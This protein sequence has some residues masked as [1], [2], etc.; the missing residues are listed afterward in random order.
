M[1]AMVRI[2]RF[3]GSRNRYFFLL[4]WLLCGVQAALFLVYAWDESSDTVQRLGILSMGSY[5]FLAVLVGMIVQTGHPGR[6]HSFFQVKPVGSATLWWSRLAWIFGV[7]LGPLYL[8]QLTPLL[9]VDPKI[10]PISAFTVYF[11]SLHG[12]AVCLLAAIAAASPKLSSYL[13][14][15]LFGGGIIIAVAML[16]GQLAYR[17]S[18]WIFVASPET[19]E[20]LWQAGLSVLGALIFAT[21]CAY[22]Y[23]GGRS[24]KVGV[25]AIASA[26]VLAAAWQPIDFRTDAGRV[27]YPVGAAVDLSEAV[28][29]AGRDHSWAGF[30]TQQNRSPGS[31]S[32]YVQSKPPYWNGG[33]EHF[34]FIPGQFKIEERDPE[35]A[36]SARL[37]DA[38]W[39]APDGEVLPYEPPA[40]TFSIRNS[41]H[42]LPPPMPTE[43]RLN[44]FFGPMPEADSVAAQ[45]GSTSIVLFGAWTSDYERYK[46]TPGRLEMR[47]RVDF[48]EHQLA[49]SFPLREAGRTLRDDQG[50]FRFAGH[51]LEGDKLELRTIALSGA[52]RWYIPIEERW[53]SGWRWMI[54]NP[55]TGRRAAATGLGTSG[56]DVASSVRRNRVNLSFNSKI[57]RGGRRMPDISDPEAL[58]LVCI[59]PR[60]LGST[61]VDV[62]VEDF[63]LVTEKSI[64]WARRDDRTSD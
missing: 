24:W 53:S 50:L 7:L 2:W 42:T 43:A 35:L 45:S 38:R 20:L 37:L 15:A 64:E 14:R 36:Y 21:V 10:G 55:E 51:S 9:W 8:A 41:T 48:Y 59:D 47:V 40:G 11:W 29:E 16:F 18:N 28:Y 25:V 26:L 4:W 13:L 34:W 39:I 54:Y 56:G 49:E 5:L 63:P 46:T 61:E 52:E 58:T 12:G 27:G 6:T 30:K 33:E 23:K 57:T 32:T 3:D 60:Y 44:T 22:L 62:V 19:A 31:Y 1:N 17:E